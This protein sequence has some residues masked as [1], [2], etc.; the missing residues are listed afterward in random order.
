MWESERVG[1]REMIC[2][3]EKNKK[4]LSGGMQQNVGLGWWRKHVP[5]NLW[6]G[7]ND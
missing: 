1:E 4:A 5:G 7:E 3:L 6:L 2:S